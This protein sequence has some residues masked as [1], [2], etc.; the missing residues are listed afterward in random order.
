MDTTVSE[1]KKLQRIRLILNC[2][3]FFPPCRFFRD[4]VGDKKQMLADGLLDEVA[5]ESGLYDKFRDMD[6]SSL[7][8]IGNRVWM[9]WYTGLDS[10]PPI[11]RKC[12]SIVSKL[13]E[14]DLV[15]I[16]KTNL[17]E[18][19][20]FEGNI[21]QYFENG[22]ISIQ[23]FSDILRC[24]LLSRGGGFWFD[25]TLFV[26]R[27]DFILTHKNLTFF[28]IHHLTNDLLLKKKWNEYFT[29]GRWS[30]YGIGAGPDNPLLSFAYEMYVEYYGL[31]QKD[32]DYFQ[33]DYTIFY[34]YTNF[35]WVRMMI[36][37]VAP[38]VSCSYFLGKNMMKPFDQKKW[39]QVIS[40]NEFQ[41]LQWKID[42]KAANR[43]TYYDHFVEL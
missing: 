41:K 27:Q 32:F 12:V 38:S 2:L 33:T 42:G 23:T 39:D 5:K 16:D 28:T 30:I 10:A 15:V 20:V 19:F 3:Q 25:A 21:K 22:N 7:K 40:E 34:A 26:T 13:P 37:S 1:I 14:V 17:E 9:F 6:L 11:V 8:P 43:K 24:Q 18:Y 29:E 36:D 4:L 31:Y 35:E